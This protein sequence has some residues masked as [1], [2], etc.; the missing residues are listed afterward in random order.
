VT[1]RRGRKAFIAIVAGAAL[2]VA[3][4]NVFKRLTRQTYT[5][6]L[7]PEPATD[8]A[9]RARAALFAELQ[10][11][12]L[13]NCELERFG[14]PNDGGYLMC[15]NLLDEVAAGYSYGISGYD[16]WGCDTSTKLRVRVHQYDCFDLD[17]PACAKGDTL[18]HEDCLAASTF[19]DKKQR[20]FDTLENQ[21]ARNGNAASRVV[22]KMDVEGAEWEAFLSAPDSVLERIDQLA[23][24]FHGTAEDR[25]LAAV[26]RLKR[27][28]HVAHLHFNN[29]ACWPGLEPFPAWAYEVLFVSKRLAVVD[30]SN[31]LVRPHRFDAPNNLRAPDCQAASA[32][33]SFHLRF[34]PAV[35]HARR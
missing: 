19:T 24:E 32:A 15:A 29:F 21:L 5:S 3:G 2:C 31:P 1:Q 10:P 22:I 9:A 26:R 13:S 11:V 30:A 14:E 28:F 6:P 20:R 8:G 16:G 25:Y 35:G 34:Q 27:F 12:R 23:I 33:T 18:F 17:R 7:S 4:V